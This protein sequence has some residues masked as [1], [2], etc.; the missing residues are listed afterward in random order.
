[1]A[2]YLIAISLCFVSWS[3]AHAEHRYVDAGNLYDLCHMPA[4]ENKD[5]CEGYFN[6][7]GTMVEF[8]NVPSDE[9]YDLTDYIPDFIDPSAKS[10]LKFMAHPQNY[11][12]WKDYLPLEVTKHALHV[13]HP[14]GAIIDK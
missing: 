6:A 12:K 8:G 2:K 3:V 13:D 11:E 14:C 4:I 9:C 1:M 5:F 7:I 10:F